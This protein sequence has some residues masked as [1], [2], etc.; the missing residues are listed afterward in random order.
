[1]R[2]APNSIQLLL[3]SLAGWISQH[4][5]E[6]I[7]YLVEENRVLK[8]QLSGRERR[9]TDDQRRRLA[10]KG[11]RIGRQALNRVA[12]IVTP[13]TIMRWHRKLVAEKW[14]HSER[15]KAVGRPRVKQEI[16]DLV[17]RFAKENPTWGYDRIQGALA[18]VG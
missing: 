11:K 12:T 6:V 7:D 9:L 4:Q 8:E 5:Q 18:N 16:V 15:R 13:D 14:D 17:L 2:A 10:A 1:M 3:L